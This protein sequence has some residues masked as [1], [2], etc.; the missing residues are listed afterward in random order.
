VGWE[1]QRERSSVRGNVCVFEKE[2]E[3]VR[4]LNMSW[5]ACVRACL[6]KC[7]CERVCVRECK[8]VCERKRECV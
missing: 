8:N 7:V 1:G 4:V 5:H 6:H 2:R 3:C